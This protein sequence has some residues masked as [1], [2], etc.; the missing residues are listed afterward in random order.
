M[1]RLKDDAKLTV[2]TTGIWIHKE[3]AAENIVHDEG[4]DHLAQNIWTFF[5]RV[6]GYEIQAEMQLL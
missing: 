2:S 5:C 4:R 3:P 6:F 1:S